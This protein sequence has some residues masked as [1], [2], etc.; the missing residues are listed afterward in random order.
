MTAG[1]YV[2]GDRRLS[3]VPHT[4][5]ADGAYAVRLAID[6]R[7]GRPAA[8]WGMVILIA[9]EAT[10]FGCFIGTY[11][12]LRFT[13][14]VWPPPGDPQPKVVV[15]LIL[16]VVLALTAI[17]MD[18]A[19]RSARAARLGPARLF[20]VVAL[21]VQLGYFAYEVVDFRDQLDRMPIT[22]DAY[23]SIYY[24]LLG[25]D[26][27]HVLI[28]MLFVVWLLWKLAFGLTTYRV[29]AAQAIAWYW[30]FVG[31]LTLVVIGTLVSA[32]I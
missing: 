4:T 21:I 22:T 5:D 1:D 19:S 23:S 9:S 29:N 15:P 2:A 3:D 25:A 16:A 32:V 11:Y 18:L 27:A 28:G 24:T 10:L 7:Y 30:Y 14:T 13:H 20:L 31:V 8:F 17:P 26:H 12:Y 6:R